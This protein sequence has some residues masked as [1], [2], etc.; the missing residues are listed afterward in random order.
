MLSEQIG[1]TLDQH[2]GDFGK[3]KGKG[4]GSSEKGDSDMG[5]SSGSDKGDKGSDKDDSSSGDPPDDDDEGDT[6]GD[7]DMQIFV[8]TPEGKVITLDVEASDTIAT[9]KTL[10]KHLEGIPKN[11]QRLIYHDQQLENDSTLSD[12]N[13]QKEDMLQLML[14]LRGAGKMIKTRIATKAT[15]STSVDDRC[16]YEGAWKCAVAIHTATELDLTS[17][18]QKM[19][20]NQL[21]DLYQYLKHDKTTNKKKSQKLVE[22]LPEHEI[23]QKAMNKI[24]IAIERLRSLTQDAAENEETNNDNTTRDINATTNTNTT[25]NNNITRMA[26]STSRASS[27]RSRTPGL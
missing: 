27:S 25:T 18:F 17:E 23:L 24:N 13:I 14:R 10:I 11:Q 6:E 9:V 5:K 22:F 1:E 8:K 19:N 4:K 15:E 7:T 12:Y 16:Y 3:G 26:S 2:R 21:D 20:T